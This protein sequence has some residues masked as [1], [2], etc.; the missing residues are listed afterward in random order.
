VKHGFELPAE[1]DAVTPA[2]KDAVIRACEW[3]YKLPERAMGKGLPVPE[4]FFC[5][6]VSEAGPLQPTQVSCAG[7]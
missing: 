2:L 4:R 3:V 7:S 5:G 6:F 1:V